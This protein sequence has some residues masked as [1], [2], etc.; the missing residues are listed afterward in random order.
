LLRGG[1]VK[2][3]FTGMVKIITKI[4]NSQ[5]L[6]LDT[7]LMEMLH[8]KVGDQV[9]LEVHEGGTATLTPIRSRPS[10]SD[11]SALISSVVKDYASTLSRLA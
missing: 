11:V 1:H 10:T 4:G 5:G 7:T 2:H 6:L 8:L 3:S 9:N